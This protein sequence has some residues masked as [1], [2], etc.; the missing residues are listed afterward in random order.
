MKGKERR[1]GQKKERKKKTKKKISCINTRKQGSKTARIRL[2]TRLL[3]SST[4]LVKVL[5]LTR[6]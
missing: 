4:D 1:T 5:F 3:K 2:N 6:R